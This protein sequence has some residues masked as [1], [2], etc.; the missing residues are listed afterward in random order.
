MENHQRDIL[1]RLAEG[2]IDVDEAQKLL[3]AFSTS[4][5]EIEKKEYQ[6]FHIQAEGDTEKE[7]VNIKVPLRLLRSGFKW[8]NLIPRKSIDKVQEKLERKG[9]EF[10]L[11]DLTKENAQELLDSLQDLEV[12]AEGQGSIRIYCS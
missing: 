9:I 2:K 11:R 6:F 10:N 7:R 12:V 8:M 1:S 5:R 3:Q 4:P